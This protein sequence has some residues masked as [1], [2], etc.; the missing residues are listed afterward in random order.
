[1]ERWE[2]KQ[3][4]SLR[5][6]IAVWFFVFTVVALLL[7]WFVWADSYHDVLDSS[8]SR[9][10]DRVA[11]HGSD[12]ASG[13]LALIED[14]AQ[15]LGKTALMRFRASEEAEFDR[16]LVTTMEELAEI[17][18]VF[19]VNVSSSE[20]VGALRKGEKINIAVVSAGCFSEHTISAS[21][22]REFPATIDCATPV[23]SRLWHRAASSM[24]S[25]QGTWSPAEMFVNG[26]TSVPVM[27]YSVASSTSG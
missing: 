6:L 24:N 10:L 12:Y 19:F 8:Y 4:S 13:Q 16:L 3:N 15:Y 27:T 2:T 5:F 22:L 25:A 1:M 11:A 21:R 20:A 7:V 26:A 18:W 14:T 9:L 17:E 23:E